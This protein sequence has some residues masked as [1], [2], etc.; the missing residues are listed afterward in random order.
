MREGLALDHVGSVGDGCVSAK[1]R[2]DKGRL[3]QL[4]FA[5]SGFKR[6]VLVDLKAI[7]ALR[8]QRDGDRDQFLVLLRYRAIGKSRLVEREEG[9]VRFGGKLARSRKLFQIVHVVHCLSPWPGRLEAT[10][11][12]TAVDG[13]HGAGD[14]A[15]IFAGKEQRGFGDIGGLT[16]AANR[17]EGVEARERL[18]DFIVAHEGVVDR[19]LNNSR[20]DRVDTDVFRSKLDCEVADQRGDAEQLRR[21]H[22]Q[23]RKTLT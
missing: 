22:A 10:S 17:V 6:G 21:L 7:G 4:F 12:H 15:C 14:P 16:V 5:R 23:L 18:S 13:E 9:L 1:G 3:S 11:G 8:G 2:G 20:G 19:G